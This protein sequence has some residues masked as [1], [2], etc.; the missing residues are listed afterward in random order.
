MAIKTRA[1]LKLLFESGDTPS[2]ADFGDLIDSFELIAGF[3]VDDDTGDIVTADGDI[4]TD[5]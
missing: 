1:E 5:D 3:V 4:V 2:A